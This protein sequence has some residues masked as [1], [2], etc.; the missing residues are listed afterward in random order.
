MRVDAILNA[1]RL[2]TLP[3]SEK[4]KALF[5]NHTIPT[6]DDWKV[7][8]AEVENMAYIMHTV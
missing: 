2:R 1:I 7:L 5:A 3:K 4:V 8:Q 6:R